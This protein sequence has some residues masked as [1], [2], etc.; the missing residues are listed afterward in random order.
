MP[1]TE[2]GRLGLH[3]TVLQFEELGFKGLR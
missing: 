2:N 1:E 3:G